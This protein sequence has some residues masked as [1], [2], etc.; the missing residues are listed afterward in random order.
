M[1]V[2]VL[3]RFLTA[4]PCVLWFIAEWVSGSNGT[5]QQRAA[6]AYFVVYGAVGVVLFSGFY[7]PA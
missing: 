3:T 6:L 2:Q 4:M 1:H 7:P 5:R